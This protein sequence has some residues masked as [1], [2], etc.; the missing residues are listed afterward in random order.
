MLGGWGGYIFFTILYTVSISSAYFV[1]SIQQNLS[2]PT[3]IKK[4]KEN[5]AHRMN[6]LGN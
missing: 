1:H 4:K 5:K 2:Q 6:K 3:Y